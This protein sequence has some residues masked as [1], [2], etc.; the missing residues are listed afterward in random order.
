VD[1][2]IQEYLGSKIKDLDLKVKEI[3]IIDPACGSGAFLNK[4]ANVLLE[5]HESIR[6][7]L[8]SKDTLD[9]VWDPIEERREILLNNI[10]GVDLNEESVDITKLSLFLKVCRKGLILPNLDKNIQCGNSV[11][12]DSDL[13][14]DKYLDW[15]QAFSDVFKKGG[16]DIVLGNP[17]YGVFTK[18]EK[19]YFRKIEKIPFKSGDSAE[20]FC[21]KC[22]DDL[23][24]PE[25]VLGF[26]IPKKSLY[27][28]PWES[29]RVDY[30]KRYD[31]MFLLDTSKSF[32]DVLLEASA[33]GLKKSNHG[34]K[35]R[36]SCLSENNMIKEFSYS[37]KDSIFL[38]N[39]TIQI[40]K[41]TYGGLFDKISKKCDYGKVKVNMGT[42]IP[43]NSLQI[44]LQRISF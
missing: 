24:K 3:K 33:Y 8:Y 6:E 16:F 23:L 38:R 12:S 15:N 17:P 36:L 27:G 11:I 4:A 28:E 25:G 31:L 18:K 14:G 37:N 20:V 32:A 43:K 42:Y 19:N 41:M 30:W 34:L 39:N 35:V 13:A 7:Q 26:I 40:Y 21:K 29:L 10:Y 22:F 5:I 2:L 44:N 1:E 9:H